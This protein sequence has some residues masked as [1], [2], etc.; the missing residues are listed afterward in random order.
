MFNT[1]FSPF[2]KPTF[3]PILDARV[4]RLGKV[5][6][7]AIKSV[8]ESFKDQV[9]DAHREGL[10]EAFARREFGGHA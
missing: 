1:I 10:A 8:N 4:S 9:D 7:D 6:I 3:D 5:G 2:F